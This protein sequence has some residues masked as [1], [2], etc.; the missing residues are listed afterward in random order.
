MRRR[1]EKGGGDT[2][3]ARGKANVSRQKAARDRTGIGSEGALEV[4]RGAMGR[5]VESPV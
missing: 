5:E 3:V 1:E 4:K 2:K